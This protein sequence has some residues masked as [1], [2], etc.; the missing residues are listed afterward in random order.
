MNDRRNEKNT[1]LSVAGRELSFRICLLDNYNSVLV[2]GIGSVSF[3]G[4][5][6]PEI[7]NIMKKLILEILAFLGQLREAVT[8]APVKRFSKKFFPGFV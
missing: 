8:F 5:E 6:R 7:Q 3:K 2:P 1:I 4:S